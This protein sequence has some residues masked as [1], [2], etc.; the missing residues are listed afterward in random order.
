MRERKV[1]K[2]KLWV[3][4]GRFLAFTCIFL[5]LL[6]IVT[7]VMKI[8][9]SVSYANIT[10]F[11]KEEKNSIDVALIGQSELYT[12]YSAPLAWE[13][14]GYTSYALSGGGLPGNL[15][16]SMLK[17]YLKEQSPKVVVFEI[18]GF[19]HSDKKYENQG[20]LHT[21]LDNIPWSENKIE[22]IQEVVPESEQYSYYFELASRHTNWRYPRKLIGGL[23]RKYLLAQRKYSYGKGFS[24]FTMREDVSRSKSFCPKFTEQSERY[25]KDL[26]EYCKSKNLE[27][28]LFV[29]FP[30]A[31]G[32]NN[33]DSIE[34][35]ENLIKF[36]GY[37]FLNLNESYEEIGLSLKTDFYN[38]EHLNVDGME[39]MNSYFGK[40]LCDHYE[41]K[42]VHS[43]DQVKHWD[44]CARK[45][46]E[47][48]KKCRQD[49][50]RGEEKQ[51][52]EISI[53]AS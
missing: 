33:L 21:W 24:T 42:N 13:E 26:L 37:D 51:Y 31:R 38:K 10:G 2:K 48:I 14:F 27:N 41:V 19:L 4:R 36:Y 53:P 20:K 5:I 23:W 17:E 16:K 30:H 46:H 50:E 52:W 49:M 43:E 3:N 34:R 22:T 40:Y 25:L 32:F 29:R 1:K 35:M 8:S 44:D 12:G 9:E 18:N 11:Y 47:V 7:D 28:V 6:V 15:Y 45:M 39:K